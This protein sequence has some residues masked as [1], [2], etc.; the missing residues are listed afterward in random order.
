MAVRYPNGAKACRQCPVEL[1]HGT[2]RV[3]EVDN[4]DAHEAVIVTTEFGH[5]TVV[6]A[7]GAVDHVG[8]AG[9]REA[10][11]TG[12]GGEDQLAMKAEQVEGLA[13]LG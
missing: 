8:I 5:A 13:A 7:A 1:R 3:V 9:V 12:E 11:T 2:S 4:A 6:G 10:H